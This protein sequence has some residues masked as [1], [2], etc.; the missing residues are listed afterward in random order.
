MITCAGQAGLLIIRGLFVINNVVCR[1]PVIHKPQM[2][3]CR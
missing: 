3:S 2:E 1:A